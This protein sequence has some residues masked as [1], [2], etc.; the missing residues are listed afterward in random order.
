MLLLFKTLPY[1]SLF[2][3]LRTLQILLHNILLEV[4]E[5]C[6]YFLHQLQQSL[7]KS[8]RLMHVVQYIFKHDILLSTMLEQKDLVVEVSYGIIIVLLLSF[9]IPT[10]TIASKFLVLSIRNFFKA[11]SALCC[12]S[13]WK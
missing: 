13:L 9:T 2:F 1:V 7:I 6:G 10:S 5:F 8:V 11:L 12:L 3:L 4:R